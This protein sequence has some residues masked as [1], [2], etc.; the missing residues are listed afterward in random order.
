MQEKIWWIEQSYTI[1]HNS[2]TYL[3]I[4]CHTHSII[5]YIVVNICDIISKNQIQENNHNNK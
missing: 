1:S 4:V 5:L 2:I 3:Y